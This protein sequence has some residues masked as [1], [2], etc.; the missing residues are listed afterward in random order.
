MTEPTTQA[1]PAAGTFCW[2]ELMLFDETAAATFYTQLFG[3]TTEV[4]G[5]GGGRI[6]HL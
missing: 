6:Y 2:N 1:P 5:M 3:W 4:M